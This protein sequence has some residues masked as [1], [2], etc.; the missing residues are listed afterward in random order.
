MSNTMRPKKKKKKK[1]DDGPSGAEDSPLPTFDALS[2][3][4]VANIF[5]FLLPKPI[6]LTSPVAAVL[7]RSKEA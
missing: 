3:D 5:G 7:S 4:D 1:L 2:T 6:S